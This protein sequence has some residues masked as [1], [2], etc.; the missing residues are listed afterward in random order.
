[1]TIMAPSPFGE[2]DDVRTT[3]TRVP[4]SSAMVTLVPSSPVTEE[5]FPSNGIVLLPDEFDKNS[6]AKATLDTGVMSMVSVIMN[7]ITPRL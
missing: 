1:M 3:A 6:F 2:K 7:V 5:L 4:S